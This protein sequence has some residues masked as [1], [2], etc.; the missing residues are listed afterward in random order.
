MPDALPRILR[1]N[2][3]GSRVQKVILLDIPEATA[4][5]WGQPSQTPTTI[6]TFSARIRPLRGDEQLNA[7]QLWPTATHYVF[8]GWLGSA[9]PARE[10]NSVTNPFTG[11]QCGLIL[12]DMVLQVVLD[13]SFLNIEFAENVDKLNRMWK[14]VCSEH[15]GAIS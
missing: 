5:T 8:L 12:P 14:L 1:D 7:R 10:G 6:G 15:I 11:Q 9:I 13:G 3:G 4:N 2:D